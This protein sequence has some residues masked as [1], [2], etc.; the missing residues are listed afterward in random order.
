[1]FTPLD[2]LDVA[3]QLERNGEKVFREAIKKVRQSDLADLLKW[4]ADQEKAHI[5]RFIE[6]KA[7]IKKPFTD[8]ILQKMGREILQETLD[9]ASF[10]LKNVD[11]SKIDEIREL[12]NLSIEFEKDTAIFYELLL[13]FVEDRETQ[14]LL[15]KIIDEEHNHAKLLKEFVDTAQMA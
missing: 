7:K 3:V 11:F 4:M 1:M 2:I 6:L 13:S 15:E 10:N 14:D 5:Q 8:P 9:G 12:L